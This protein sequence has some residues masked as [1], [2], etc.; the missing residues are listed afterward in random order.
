MRVHPRSSHRARK[1][2]DLSC[3][4]LGFASGVKREKDAEYGS[5]PLAAA[6]ADG[7]VMQRLSATE[8]PNLIEG[9]VVSGGMMPKLEACMRIGPDWV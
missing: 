3:S 7:S 8:V 2:R 9:S 4:S 5:L 1:Q 6:D